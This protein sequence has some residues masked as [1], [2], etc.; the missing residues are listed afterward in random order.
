VEA[1][2][3]SEAR[4]GRV[5]LVVELL[6]REAPG[7]DQ[8]LLPAQAAP[9]RTA[10]APRPET[11]IVRRPSSPTLAELA[12]RALRG[13]DAALAAGDVEGALGEFA[14]ALE[15]L[16]GSV[17]ARERLARTLVQAGRADEALALLSAEAPP[18]AAHP[19]YHALRAALLEQDGQHAQAAE[20]YAHLVRL[21]P[22]RAAWWLGLGIS[23]EGEQR[24]ADALRV[25]R[26]ATALDG[27]APEPRDWALERARSLEGA[28]R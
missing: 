27:L 21:D 18:V 24:P 1:V 4:D 2:G 10:Q 16:P 12:A 23:L 14:R 22:Q 9:A 13:G 28:V 11:R 17:Q 20:L 26:T 25:Y 8:D 19:E 15:M 6:A 7:E 5:A 3:H